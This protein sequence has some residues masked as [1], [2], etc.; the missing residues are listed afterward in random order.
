MTRSRILM[1]VALLLASAVMATPARAGTVTGSYSL[2]RDTPV[3]AGQ[4]PKAAAWDVDGTM[5]DARHE[6]TVAG[7]STDLVVATRIDYVHAQLR[8]ASRDQTITPCDD[9]VDPADVTTISA[10][11]VQAASSVFEADVE[12]N[13]LHR[14]GKLQFTIAGAPYLGS[15]GYFQPGITNLSIV[16]NCW[17]SPMDRSGPTPVFDAT[18][19]Y[20][21][22][23]TT[24]RW[25][26]R[27]HWPLVQRADGSWHAGGTSSAANDG[28]TDHATLDLTLRGTPRSLGATCHMPTVRDLRA[29]RTFA[30]ARA[31]MARAGFAR[32]KVGSRASRAAPRGRFFVLEGVG[33]GN[34]IDCGAGGLHLLRSLGWPAG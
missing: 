24:A 31:V 18:S 4:V 20:M 1:T 29:V 23:D 34:A 33:N 11:G 27:L 19:S 21:F 25:T 22:G 26:Q 28:A 6:A 13:L 3:W 7:M 16:T 8:T 9:G 30:A 2:S 17:G 12:L 32:V 14:T 10:S 5:L 15:P